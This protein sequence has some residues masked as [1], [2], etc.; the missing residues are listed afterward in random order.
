MIPPKNSLSIVVPAYNEQVNL[1]P[2][3]LHI[4]EASNLLNAEFEIII[5]N[6]CSKD[7]TAG[8]ADQLAQKF[9]FVRV[10]N[11][12]VNLGF[13]GAYKRGVEES[14]MA[15]TIM[16]PGD[17]AYPVTALN[18]IFSK[19]G[20]ADMVMSY[21]TNMQ[22]RPL[23]R[24][25][26]SRSFVVF[27]NILFGLKLKYY[28]GVSVLPTLM[29]QNMKSSD[30]FGYAAENVVRLIKIHQYTYAQV[31]VEITERKDGKSNAFNA[32]NIWLVVRGLI[33][34]TKDVYFAG[35]YSPKK[36]QKTV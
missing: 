35:G 26:I 23:I 16:I 34:L 14:R 30:G 27:L 8:V 36:N 25:V 19:V 11:N 33:L 22:V 6:D 1:E 28:N 17:D 5:V 18:T 29:A 4:I 9:K 2:T 32:K 10:L 7:N 31:P 13:G 21:T 15:Y 20:T 24:R 3:V 12:S